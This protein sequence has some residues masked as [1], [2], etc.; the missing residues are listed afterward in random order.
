MTG[1]V[2]L[3]IALPDA[4]HRF[5]RFLQTLRPKDR[6]LVFCHYDADGL[7]AGALFGRGLTRLG[8]N[9]V[10]VVAAARG[11]SAFSDQARSRLAARKPDALIITDLGVHSDGVLN[12]VPTLFVDHHQPVGE[13]PGA[14]VITGY[15]WDP[16]P[17]SAWLAWELLQS[18]NDMSGLD[19][20][21]AV[22]TISDLGD[23][24]PWPDLPAIRKRW[25]AKWLKEAVVLVNAARRAS[26]FDVATPL[27]LL[28]EASHPR[29]ISQATDRGADRLHA[30]R[31]EVHA[32]LLLARRH[33][34]SF[35]TTGP[36][37]LVRLHSRCQIHPLIAQQWRTRLP[38]YAV[39]AA[40]TGYMPDVVA[41][42]MR[43]AR[44]DL[45]LPRLLRSIDLG[46][47]G[48]FGGRFGHGH[49]QASGGHLPPAAFATLLERLGVQAR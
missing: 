35:S 22:G 6:I 27:R 13:P 38:K 26:A 44:R 16:I 29:E 21:A 7:A 37:A 43:T 32:E 3:E 28:L 24:A 40:N 41:F 34:P 2:P 30:Y 17:A 25:T 18:A 49:D 1:A 20:I 12:D 9:G 15:G 10:D 48:D 33:A 46:D 14:E 19:W 23:R 47:V 11:E 31:A 8:F 45:D 5:A 42:S 39:I 4:R 36:Y